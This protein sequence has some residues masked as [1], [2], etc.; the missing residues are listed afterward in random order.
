MQLRL[1]FPLRLVSSLYVALAHVTRT[2]KRERL[3]HCSSGVC[4]YV[5]MY[6]GWKL[7][8]LGIGLNNTWYSDSQHPMSFYSP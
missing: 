8:S 4:I 7:D 2:I 6:H 3:V 5:S 1:E